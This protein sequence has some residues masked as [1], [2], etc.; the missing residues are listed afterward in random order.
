MSFEHDYGEYIKVGDVV[1]VTARYTAVPI[2]HPDVVSRAT[3]IA[4]LNS[5]MPFASREDSLHF[6]HVRT[7]I[8]KGYPPLVNKSGKLQS[9][10]LLTIDSKAFGAS[11]AVEA[12]Q[13]PSRKSMVRR[14]SSVLD[15]MR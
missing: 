14:L 4:Y 6:Y 11:A 10:H 13:A 3:V 5:H 8:C 2:D 12:L 15:E 1:G 7:T 9:S